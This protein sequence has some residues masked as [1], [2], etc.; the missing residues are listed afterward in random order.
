MAG[1]WQ[2]SR[3]GP[4]YQQCPQN[5]QATAPSTNVGLGFEHGSPLHNWGKSTRVSQPSA[6]DD[7]LSLRGTHECCIG[8]LAERLDFGWRVG[9]VGTLH[10]G[11]AV[12]NRDAATACGDQS[13]ARQK[14]DYGYV[15]DDIVHLLSE[16]V[17]KAGHRS[18]IR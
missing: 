2:V 1:E 17:V 9:A 5:A 7:G 16:D 12:D 8:H 11:F 13:I 6:P 18:R 10:Q 4:H 15:E 14:Y 3:D